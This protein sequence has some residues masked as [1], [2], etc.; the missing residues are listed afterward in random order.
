MNKQNPARM[1][2]DMEAKPPVL[3][4]KMKPGDPWIHYRKSPYYVAD[5]QI[6]NGSP[7]YATM[8]NAYKNHGVTYYTPGDEA[9]ENASGQCCVLDQ[10]P[11]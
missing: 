6:S 1:R 5:H 9:S 3:M 10:N 11:F 2:W 7:G 8:Q 4:F